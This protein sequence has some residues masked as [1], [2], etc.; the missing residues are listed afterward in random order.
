MS[1][2]EQL[3]PG[4]RI[5]RDVA[6]MSRYS[7]D[8]IGTLAAGLLIFGGR[9]IVLIRHSL[10]DGRLSAP[11]T[12]DDVGYLTDALHRIS[13]LLSD[14]PLRLIR[15]FFTSPP[16]SPISTLIG[17]VSFSLS[18]SASFAPY[19]ANGLLLGLVFALFVFHLRATWVLRLGIMLCAAL[20]PL[21]DWAIMTFRPDIMA[22]LVTACI[23]GMLLVSDIGRLTL[24]RAALLGVGGGLCLLY[25]PTAVMPAAALLATALGL[26]ILKTRVTAGDTRRSLKAA[27]VMIGAGVLTCAPYFI[28]AAPDLIDY[29]RFAM[30]ENAAVTELQGGLVTQLAFYPDQAAQM[31]GANAM[32]VAGLALVLFAFCWRDRGTK[33]TLACFFAFAVAAYAIPTIP[34]VKTVMFGAYFYGAVLVFLA[35]ALAGAARMAPRPAA[36][37][38]ALLVALQVASARPD[39]PPVNGPFVAAFRTIALRVYQDISKQD[40][41]G[42]VDIY[43]GFPWP[44]GQG[45]LELKSAQEGKPYRLICGPDIIRGYFKEELQPYIDSINHAAIVVIPSP[46]IVS[47]F[48]QRLPAER[49]LAPTLAYVRSDPRFDLIDKIETDWGP[50]YVFK[51]RGR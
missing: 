43:L 28:P 38:V 48:S 20:L 51:N 24:R 29:I 25:K 3:N 27:T 39:Q 8:L 35:F 49:F 6:S 44:L 4:A 2:V 23:C 22:G 17:A 46:D 26:A 12:D 30:L 34:V 33:L 45:V 40:F 47:H 14:G 13:T 7:A 31:L 11:L 10:V 1:A 15:E 50:A 5:P 16:H 18:G 42:G 21:T 37:S 32:L 41:R 9:A 36:T 19:L